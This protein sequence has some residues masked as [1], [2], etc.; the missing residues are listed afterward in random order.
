LGC[1]L[2]LGSGLQTR[3]LGVTRPP[4]SFMNFAFLDQNYSLFIREANCMDGICIKNLSL[5]ITIFILFLCMKINHLKRGGFKMDC[6]NCGNKKFDIKKV[7]METLLKEEKLEVLTE[8]FVCI[9]CNHEMMNT[10]QMAKFRVFTADTYRK[11]HELLTSNESKIKI[12]QN[13]LYKH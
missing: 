13:I 7:L 6:I 4:Q 12:C 10:E 11:N 5:E 9:K 1:V 3:F 8:A 2:K